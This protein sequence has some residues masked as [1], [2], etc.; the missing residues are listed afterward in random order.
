MGGDGGRKWVGMKG[1]REWVR[2]KGVKCE[3][4]VGAGMSQDHFQPMLV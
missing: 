3:S 2:M 1:G 4:V